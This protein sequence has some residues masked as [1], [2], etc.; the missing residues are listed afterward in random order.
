[1]YVCVC[2]CACVGACGCV[3]RHEGGSILHSDNEAVAQAFVGALRAMVMGE[4]E[5]EGGNGGGGRGQ[6]WRVVLYAMAGEDLERVSLLAQKLVRRLP[7]SGSS[8][9]GSGGSSSGGSGSGEFEYQYR[10]NVLL[11]S[12]VLDTAG[13]YSGTSK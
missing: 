2:V 8:G 12:T 4:A 3:G 1:M 7:G 13:E 9:S 5:A 11:V 6:R 10:D